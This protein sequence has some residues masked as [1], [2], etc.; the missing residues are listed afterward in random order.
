MRTFL[1]AL[2]LVLLVPPALAQQ[3][4]EHEVKAAF[5]FKFPAF[6]EWPNGGASGRPF[7]IAAAGAPDVV[8]ELARIAEG[9]QIHG[10]PVRVR[11]LAEGESAA[12]VQMVFVG[13]DSPRLRELVRALA[14]TPTLVVSDTPAGLEQG[15][16]INFVPSE[17]RVRFDVAPAA[18]EKSGLRLS[19][20][21]L[22]VAQNVRGPRL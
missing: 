5:L 19:S 2:L 10:R 17:G 6:V 7:V 22:A 3:A 12:G 13:R 14:G 16:M 9:R 18:A 1:G 4:L 15:A 11:A 8:A 21:L 20:R